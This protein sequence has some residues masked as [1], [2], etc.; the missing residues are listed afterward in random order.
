M[1]CYTGRIEQ[2]RPC[3]TPLTSLS[4]SLSHLI[5]CLSSLPLHHRLHLHLSPQ[6]PKSAAVSAEVRS[7]HEIGGHNLDRVCQTLESQELFSPLKTKIFHPRGKSKSCTTC[8][9]LFGHVVDRAGSLE[10]SIVRG[11]A[12]SSQDDTGYLWKGSVFEA[13]PCGLS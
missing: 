10:Q 13:W 7:G 11:R 3:N 9:E 2:C 4:P 1:A 5:S 6:S 12:H 8:P